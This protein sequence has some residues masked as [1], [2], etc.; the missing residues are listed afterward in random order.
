MMNEMRET[1]QR[2]MLRYQCGHDMV[3]RG[4]K[5]I[6]DAKRAVSL[7]FYTQDQKT[8]GGTKVVCSRCYDAKL[9]GGRIES[10]MQGTAWPH[11]V[12]TDG[13]TLWRKRP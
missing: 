4:C 2:N 1:I 12:V 10:L 7:D 13:R 8:L 9:S 6:L 5:A 3:C 11:I